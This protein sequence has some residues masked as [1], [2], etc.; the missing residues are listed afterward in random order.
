MFCIRQ[1]YTEGRNTVCQLVDSR[2]NGSRT[3]VG[4][5][6]VRFKPEVTEGGSGR[7]RGTHDPIP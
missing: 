5:D 6:D 4:M 2:S 7:E 3:R 1:H